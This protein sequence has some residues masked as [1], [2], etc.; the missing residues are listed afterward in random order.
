M[1]TFR[2]T[3]QSLLSGRG[4]RS[5]VP[6]VRPIAIRE[7][8]EETSVLERRVNWPLDLEAGG[9]P[10]GPVYPK[11]WVQRYLGTSAV[12]DQMLAA[13]WIAVTEGRTS[14]ADDAYLVLTVSALTSI[15][16]FAYNNQELTAI[17]TA[18]TLRNTGTTT[19]LSVGLRYAGNGDYAAEPRTIYYS[20]LEVREPFGTYHFRVS[21]T[22]SGTRVPLLGSWGY[23]YKDTVAGDVEGYDFAGPEVRVADLTEV[24]TTPAYV[25]LTLRHWIPGET[26]VLSYSAS[27]L[28]TLRSMRLELPVVME[29]GNLL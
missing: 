14:R 16:S 7:R 4:V 25:L 29:G 27:R 24:S 6:G 10:G 5:V 1:S 19:P 28:G 15:G 8:E 3:S 2:H 20:A 18:A 23:Y 17:V 12:P 21:Q 13:D 26:G 11:V 9:A 22:V